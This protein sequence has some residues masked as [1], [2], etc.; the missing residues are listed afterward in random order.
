MKPR[1]LGLGTALFLLTVIGGGSSASASFD[2]TDYEAGSWPQAAATADFNRDGYPD[3]AV[4][5]CGAASVSVLLNNGD[6]TFGFKTDYATGSNP[7]SLAAGDFN[8]DGFPDL[9]VGNG[10]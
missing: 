6:G 3:V 4:V 5:N 2:R 10:G 8:G 7:C 9:V 1:S